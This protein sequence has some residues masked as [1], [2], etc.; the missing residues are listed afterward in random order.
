MSDL[1]IRLLIYLTCQSVL[2]LNWFTGSNA[3]RNIHRSHL[4]WISFNLDQIEGNPLSYAMP[5]PANGFRAGV[6]A[7]SR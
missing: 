3:I 1:H 5:F 7:K 6:R 4:S 2:R